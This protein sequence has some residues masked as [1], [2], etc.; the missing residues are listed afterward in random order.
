M[1]RPQPRRFIPGTAARIAWNAEDRLIAMIA[2]HFSSG[3]SSIGATC[4]MPALLTSTSTRPNVLS[5]SAIMLETSI[6][7]PMLAG[8]YIAFTPKSFS[9][10]DRVFST[11]AGA[12]IPLSM[13]LAPAPANARAQARPIPLVEPRRP[14]CPSEYSFLLLVDLAA[15]VVQSARLISRRWTGCWT[16]WRR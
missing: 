1:M 15:C 4:W 16:G 8:E 13:T 5:A 11:S 2:S 14:S 9:I 10:A 7:S 6:G 12:P 3:N